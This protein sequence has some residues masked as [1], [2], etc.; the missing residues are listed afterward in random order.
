MALILFCTS[1]SRAPKL[2]AEFCCFLKPCACLSQPYGHYWWST[3]CSH[4]A[5]WVVSHRILHSVFP[6]HCLGFIP[7]FFIHSSPGCSN[8]IFGHTQESLRLSCYCFWFIDMCANQ[9][10]LPEQPSVLVINW[11]VW[12]EA[13]SPTGSLWKDLGSSKDSGR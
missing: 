11:W 13:K 1:V 4:K 6:F 8:W 9:M 2:N 10:H 3:L 12:K 5:S 7:P